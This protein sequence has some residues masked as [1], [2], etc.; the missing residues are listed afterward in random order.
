MATWATPEAA[1]WRGGLE[2]LVSPS[3]L[4]HRRLGGSKGQEAPQAAR[5][6]EERD[7]AAVRPRV[8]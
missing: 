1:R 4:A 6:P 2:L 3:R 5:R 8:E 7:C